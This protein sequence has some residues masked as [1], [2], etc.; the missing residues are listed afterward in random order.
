MQVSR[1]TCQLHRTITKYYLQKNRG[2][3]KFC[4]LLRD[5]H[6]ITK[7]IGKKE[8]NALHY[9]VCCPKDLL[10]KWKR[11]PSIHPWVVQSTIIRPTGIDRPIVK[12]ID[13]PVSETQG[14]FKWSSW[15]LSFPFLLSISYFVWKNNS[16]ILKNFN[17]QSSRTPLADKEGQLIGSA[18]GDGN[19]RIHLLHKR[20]LRVY[21][22]VK[23][24]SF[25]L[26]E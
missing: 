19:C 24:M 7:R 25:I 16:M 13:F 10:R 9:P 1:W 22:W 6:R 17:Q 26:T 23:E 14:V 2:P 12:C 3:S 11:S 4:L 15:L 5:G 21:V 20:A 8:Q 18:A